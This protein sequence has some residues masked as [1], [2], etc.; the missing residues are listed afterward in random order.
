M[1]LQQP[2]QIV[3]GEKLFKCKDCNEVKEALQFYFDKV[4]VYKK[5]GLPRRLS[6]CKDCHRRR[7][8]SHYLINKKAL[9]NREL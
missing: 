8:K 4:L 9:Q 6:Y 1:T 7:V 3:K 5:T 2:I